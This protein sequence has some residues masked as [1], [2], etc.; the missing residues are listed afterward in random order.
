ML[1][2]FLLLLIEETGTSNAQ[3]YTTTSTVTTGNSHVVLGYDLM[4]LHC[5]LLWIDLNS[6]QQ[7]LATRCLQTASNMEKAWWHGLAVTR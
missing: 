4:Y 1:T 5:C 3:R 7:T 6:V 2:Q